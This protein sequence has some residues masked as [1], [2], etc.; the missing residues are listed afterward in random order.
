MKKILI[1]SKSKDKV[2]NLENSTI[3][4]SVEN[5]DKIPTPDNSNE[6]HLR[7]P[8]TGP[9]R[10]QLKILTPLMSPQTK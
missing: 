1:G 5:A 2:D 4:Q 8:E 9:Q 7:T 6:N 3:Q 10:F